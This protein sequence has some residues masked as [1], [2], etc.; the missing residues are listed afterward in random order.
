MFEQQ[1]FMSECAK[2][3]ENIQ[4]L[5]ELKRQ[6]DAVIEDRKVDLAKGLQGELERQ[7]AL[8]HRKFFPELDQ[9][10]ESEQTALGHF[11]GEEV[12]VPLPPA[13]ITSKRFKRWKE[14]GFELHY[15]PAKKVSAENSFSG[16]REKVDGLLYRAM[17]EGKL[18]PD[19]DEMRG[20]WV[21]VDTRD[22][23]V[24]TPRPGFGGGWVFNEYKDDF[25]KDL[26]KTLSWRQKLPSRHRSQFSW[27]QLQDQ[28]TKNKFAD[29]L[30]VRQVHPNQI[31]LPRAVEWNYLVNEFFPWWTN[32]E[33]HI[34]EWLEDRYEGNRCLVM[35]DGGGLIVRIDP[36]K[37]PGHIGFRLVIRFS[38]K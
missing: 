35:E 33:K 38:Q 23:P 34:S 13:E 16:Q 30:K 29:F 27:E 9:I 8:V 7:L 18:E 4:R 24:C 31:T 5:H 22:V 11:F 25:L 6:F 1:Q 14:L 19:S 36:G 3:S 12:K 32:E 21:L 37:N 17:K 10:V 28:E 20:E 15:F 2:N 26:D